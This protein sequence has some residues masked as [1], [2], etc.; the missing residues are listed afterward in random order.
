MC[1]S[2]N[3]EAGP[4]I[5]KVVCCAVVIIFC[6]V[7]ALPRYRNGIDMSD[8]GF[9]AYGAVRVLNGELPNRDFVSL[10]PP[11]SF[12]TVAAVFKFLGTSLV[13]LRTLGLCFYIVIALL[14]F[15]ISRRFTGPI[16]ALI[17]AMLAAILGM[18][19]FNFTPFAVWHGIVASLMTLLFILKFTASNQRR[20]ALLAGLTTALAVL[21]RHDQG[22]Y[23]TIAV[24]I[25]ALTIKLTNRENPNSGKM[26]VFGAVGLAATI[27]PLVIYWIICGAL[28]YMFRQLVIFPLTTY[29]KTSSLPFPVF[30]RG[31][32]LLANLITCLFY[33]P[34]LIEVLVI[35][36]LAIRL[37]RRRFLAEHAPVVFILIT[38]VLFY[39]QVLARS[40]LYHLLMTLPPFFILLA[41]NIEA[42]L[43]LFHKRWISIGVTLVILAVIAS[44]LLYTA[45]V[46]VSPLSEGVKMISLKRG[47]VK[48]TIPLAKFIENTNG[49]IQQY[50]RP[51]ESILCLPYQPMFYFLSER[52]NPTRWNYLWPGDQTAED[53][54]RLIEQADADPPAV[55]VLSDRKRMLNYAPT[56]IDYINKK[57]KA[58]HDYGFAATYI[59][60]DR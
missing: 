26:L 10:Q 43:G 23:L 58:T 8:E 12:Y 55:V 51:D 3:T 36:W 49:V 15:V 33:L 11:L 25:Y 31:A 41:W 39:C 57:Y 9:L 2:V 30:Q 18:P 16:P 24:L 44:F 22:F 6:L 48:T 20:W 59:L 37:V 35:I 5:G 42:V 4:S 14:V 19:F 29:A 52:R 50:S 27:A 7:L 32:P 1:K 47:G 53:H 13:S 38:S 45:P 40:D 34:P 21:S 46:F 28:P 56:I 17:A 54:K 60:L